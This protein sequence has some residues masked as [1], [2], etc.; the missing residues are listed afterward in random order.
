M[1]TEKNEFKNRK[2]EQKN[3]EFPMLEQDKHQR[4]NNL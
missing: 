2:P 1:I 3:K 4:E